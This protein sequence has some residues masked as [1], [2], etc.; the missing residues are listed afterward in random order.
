MHQDVPTWSFETW[1]L[2][3]LISPGSLFFLAFFL[4]FSFLTLFFLIFFLLFSFLTLFFLIF[5][6]LFSFLILFFLYSLLTIS[7]YYSQF[8]SMLFFSS[9]YLFSSPVR[10]VPF[11][12]VQDLVMDTDFYFETPFIY[13]LKQI[14][15]KYN[16]KNGIKH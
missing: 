2:K 4:L 3:I 9:F 6:L 12:H 7:P 10:S 16:I 5:F 1:R 11:D 15:R 14:I 8:F 13:R